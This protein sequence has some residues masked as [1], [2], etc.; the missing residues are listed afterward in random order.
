MMIPTRATPANNSYS[1]NAK[2]TTTTQTRMLEITVALATRSIR[3]NRSINIKLGDNGIN[4]RSKSRAMIAVTIMA[5]QTTTTQA[6][7]ASNNGNINNTINTS[8]KHMLSNST[9]FGH[10][11]NICNNINNRDNYMSNDHSY[12]V[13]F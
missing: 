1:I 5:A 9:Y 6:D 10:N 3:S 7:K 11:I 8:S 2:T 12:T 4:V 13:K